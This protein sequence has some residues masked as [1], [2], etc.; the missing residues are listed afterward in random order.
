MKRT[1]RIVI[2]SLAMIMMFSGFMISDAKG[3]TRIETRG[4][5]LGNGIISDQVGLI[6]DFFRARGERNVT[7]GYRYDA[8]TTSLVR[9]YQAQKGLVVDGY[10]GPATLAQM[11][12]DII[13]N[14]YKIG[15]RVPRANVSGN[16]L[17]LNKS[18][19]TLHL[20]QNGRTIRTYPIA[21]GRHY[22]STPDGKH[23]IVNKR[24]NSSW[25][26]VNP[27][28]PY[29]PGGHPNNPLGTRW[30]GLNYGGGSLYGIHGNA[31]RGSIGHYVS[32]GCVRMFN[33]DVE[34]LFSMVSIGTPVW[35][36]NQDLLENYGVKFRIE[37]GVNPKPSKPKPP[38][39]PKEEDKIID[40]KLEI[41]GEKINLENPVMG[42]EGTT[43]YPLKELIETIDGK[44]SWDQ[45]SRTASG[46]LGEDKVAF[47]IDKNTY[48]VNG[49]S[50]N[51][52]KGEKAFIS[53]S[54][55]T[56]IPIRYVMEAFGYEVDWD[57]A[58]RTVIVTSEV[59]EPE[60]EEPEIEVPEEDDF[61]EGWELE[62]LEI[63][64]DYIKEDSEKEDINEDIIEDVETDG[65]KEEADKEIEADKEV[66]V[67]KKEETDKEVEDGN[68]KEDK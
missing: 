30:L 32:Q 45:T 37:Y 54:Q 12:R 66:E 19:N 23:R 16:L 38:A 57:Q 68:L 25:Q 39:K 10:S 4:L 67:D 17:V 62:D 24:I 13:N 58:T 48:M 1:K 5:V 31:D 11:N 2:V 65:P 40:A 52:P 51:L 56:Y 41:D 50:K 49:V 27:G 64:E 8:R 63:D 34:Q 14:N 7:W 9:N 61:F 46:V 29:I 28:D 20:L 26:G 43:Y 47:T 36:G 22:D 18:S 33:S 35:I 3:P 15:P 55:K 6:K 44:V 21:T 53:K 60:I 59:E 42:R